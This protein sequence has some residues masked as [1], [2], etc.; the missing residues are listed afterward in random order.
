ML[1]L[2]SVGFIMEG[3]GFK[4]AFNQIFA[5]NSAEKALI[6]HA[7]SRAVR[8]YSLVQIALANIIFSTINF[9]E[10]ELIELNS[11]I[12][13]LEKKNQ[14]ICWTMNVSTKKSKNQITSEIYS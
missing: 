4:E 10:V 7:F 6:G 11:V 14:I 13:N 3:N 2:G 9:S 8:G 12:A 1:F 5:G